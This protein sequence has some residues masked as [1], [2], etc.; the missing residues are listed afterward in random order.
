MLNPALLHAKKMVEWP[1]KR[2][3]AGLHNEDTASYK[4]QV[5][6][7]ITIQRFKLPK[8]LWGWGGIEI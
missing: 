8:A 1:N 3:L 4:E 2:T 6:Y 5:Y 7:N